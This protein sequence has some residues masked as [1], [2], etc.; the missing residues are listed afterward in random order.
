MVNSNTA[1]VR[2]LY[3]YLLVVHDGDLFWLM[4]QVVALVLTCALLRWV[5]RKQSDYWWYVTEECE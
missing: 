1:W 2:T 4:S 3:E 5:R